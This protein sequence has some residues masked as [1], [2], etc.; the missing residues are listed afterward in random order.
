M[1]R[2]LYKI[3]AWILIIGGIGYAIANLY[4]STGPTTLADKIYEFVIGLLGSIVIIA[5]SWF[6]GRYYLRI[7]ED[8]S[9]HNKLTNTSIMLTIIGIILIIV[10]SLAT[11]ITC[12]PP[13]MT[14]CDGFGIILFFILGLW[15]AGFLYAIAI[16][17]LLVNKFK[18]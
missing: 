16:I 14:Y 6:P 11:L 10:T 8:T 12:P 15:P 2:L 5:L 9:K 4:F 1:N 3:T 13:N 18:K 7:S 17:L